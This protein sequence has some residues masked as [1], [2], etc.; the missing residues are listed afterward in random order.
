MD[1]EFILNKIHELYN[2]AVS[3]HDDAYNLDIKVQFE[4]KDIEN[5]VTPSVEFCT[6]HFYIDDKDDDVML[7]DIEFMRGDKLPI[8]KLYG[9]KYDMYLDEFIIDKVLGY[10]YEKRGKII[11]I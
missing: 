10:I 9:N 5:P 8:L 4:P 3:G 7:D 6:S 11:E 1:K 2:I